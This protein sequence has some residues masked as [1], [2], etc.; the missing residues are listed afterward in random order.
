MPSVPGNAVKVT[1][2]Y[3]NL[4]KANRKFF[5]EQFKPV[6]DDLWDIIDLQLVPFGNTFKSNDGI[7]DCP[8]G[9]KQCYANKIQV[10]K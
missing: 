7:Y 8:Y 3:E 9:E 4:N 10:T 5:I 2:F 1:V 6:F